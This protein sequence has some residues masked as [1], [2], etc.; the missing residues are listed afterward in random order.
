MNNFLAALFGISPSYM[1]MIFNGKRKITYKMAD[2]LHPFK[3]SRRAYWWTQIGVSELQVE[4][5][6]IYAKQLTEQT[7]GGK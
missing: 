2:R 7:K 5:R 1:S 3:R 4:L 6:R